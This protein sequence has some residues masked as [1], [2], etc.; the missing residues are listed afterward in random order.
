MGSVAKAE[1]CSCRVVPVN[2]VL[3]KTSAR[4]VVSVGCKAQQQLP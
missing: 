1:Q 3:V 4:A 2:A